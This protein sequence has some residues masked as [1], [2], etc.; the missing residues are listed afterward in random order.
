MIVVS[1]PE[2]AGQMLLAGD[3]PAPRRVR[4][5]D[6]LVTQ[7]LLPTALIVRRADGTGAIGNALVAP[8]RG[9]GHRSIAAGF[10]RPKSA[11]R[12]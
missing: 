2:A 5:A 10:G 9:A 1:R 11:V 6:C 8:A 4:C 12:R 3:A 7:I